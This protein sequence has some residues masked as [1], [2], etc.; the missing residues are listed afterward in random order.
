MA[1]EKVREEVQQEA[2][3][4]DFDKFVEVRKI[5]SAF[6]EAIEEM[7]LAT[8]CLTLRIKKEY[9][10]EVCKLL[11]DDEETKYDF[12][13]D[14]TGA[15]Y[16]KR[17]KPLEVVYHLCSIP[18]AKRLRLKVWLSEDE[19][20]E[21]VCSVWPSANWFEREAYDLVGIR[22]ANHP[23]LRRI[24][25]P[26]DWEGYPLRKDYPLEG[27]PGYREKWLRE[28]LPYYNKL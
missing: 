27:P 23:D 8:D 11:R 28:H 2:P 3:K 25:L 13:A 18:Y 21:S 5:K 24:L 1:E 10:V 19:E 15:H 16:P 12:L 17:E 4:V 9:I 26:E 14:I 22:F 7:A 6:P 20:V